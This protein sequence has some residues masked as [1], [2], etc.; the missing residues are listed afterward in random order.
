M[1]NLVCLCPNVNV[2]CG[3]VCLFFFSIYALD[4][5]P[6]LNCRFKP[7][8]CSFAEVMHTHKLYLF[9]LRF[10]FEGMFG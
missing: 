5:I 7:F 9:L 10:C 8:S 3:F 1:Q 4:M 6:V 2:F